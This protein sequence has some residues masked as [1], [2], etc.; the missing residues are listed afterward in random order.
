MCAPG[1]PWSTLLVLIPVVCGL[2]S[3]PSHETGVLI[4]LILHMRKLPNPHGQSA[5]LPKQSRKTTSGSP[6]HCGLTLDMGSVNCIYKEPAHAGGQRKGVWLG[7]SAPGRLEAGVG[8]WWVSMP[9]QGQLE[10]HRPCLKRQM[11]SRMV[12]LTLQGPS[13]VCC[14]CF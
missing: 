5:A 1:A 10:P 3:Q 11:K 12:L 2:R 8:V 14:A 6:A 9:L 7:L 13:H 4:S